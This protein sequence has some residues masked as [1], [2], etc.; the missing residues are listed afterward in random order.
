MDDAGLHFGENGEAAAK[1]GRVAAAGVV[2]VLVSLA[3]LLCRIVARAEKRKTVSDVSFSSFSVVF[4]SDPFRLL[5]SFFYS[6]MRQPQAKN[7]RDQ[8][9]GSLWGRQMA[10]QIT[11]HLTNV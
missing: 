10:Q 8:G 4:V 1:D 3:I 5:S 9:Q 6:L 2:A 11:E 7:R